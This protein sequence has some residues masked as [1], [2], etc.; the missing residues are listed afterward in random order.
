MAT[1]LV[2][3]DNYSSR[4]M[5]TSLLGYK[6]HRLFE[7]ANGAEA[8]EIARSE[9]PDLIIADLLMPVMDGYEFARQLRADSLIAHTPLIFYT[10]TYALSEAQSLAD[11][12]GAF[13]L[14]AKPADPETVLKVVDAALSGP[15]VLPG[16]I[17][18]KLFDV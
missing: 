1:I 17:E 12:C 9:H 5:L 7:A 4:K 15:L 8:L 13:R 10:A 3:E 18:D 2:A 11:I 6:G 14:L 16:P